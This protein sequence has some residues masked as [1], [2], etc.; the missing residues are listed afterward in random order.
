MGRATRWEGVEELA[1]AGSPIGAGGG[2][3]VRF[4]HYHTSHYHI[5]E[6]CRLPSPRSKSH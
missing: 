6:I 4:T 3:S 1:A 5:N 2:G